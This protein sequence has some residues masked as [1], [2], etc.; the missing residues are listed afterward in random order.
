[1][2]LVLGL[3]NPGA[4]YLDTRH[5][6]GFLVVDAVARRAAV[7]ID[8]AAHEALSAKALVRGVPCVLAKPQTFMNLSGQPGQKLAAFYKVALDHVIVV[9]DELDLPL[10]DVRV[11]VGGG[12]GGHNGLRDLAKHLEGPAFVRVRVGIGRPPAGWDTANYVLGRWSPDEA[13]RLPDVVALAADVVEAVVTDGP[14]A[15][16]NRF[17][18]APA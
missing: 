17:H 10:G 14:L 4:R 13:S 5:N 15:A 12:H 6:A 2:F 1:M 18:G 9:H 11:K 16:Q 8:K 7:S 3:G